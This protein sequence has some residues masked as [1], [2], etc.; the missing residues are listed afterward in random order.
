MESLNKET[1][2]QR[3]IFFILDCRRSYL[4]TLTARNPEKNIKLINSVILIENFA[5]IFG[6]KERPVVDSLE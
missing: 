5:E 2:N 3:F 4:L 6:S 1:G